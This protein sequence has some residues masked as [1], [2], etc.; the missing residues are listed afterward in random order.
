MEWK[1]KRRLTN[2]KKYLL[3]FKTY[4]VFRKGRTEEPKEKSYMGLEKSN[5]D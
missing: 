5:Y 2:F 4:L 1:Q 3:Q